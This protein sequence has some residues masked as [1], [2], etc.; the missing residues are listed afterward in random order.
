MSTTADPYDGLDNIWAVEF[1]VKRLVSEA[2][3]IPTDRILADKRTVWAYSGPV[4][5]INHDKYENGRLAYSALGVTHEHVGTNEQATMLIQQQVPDARNARIYKHEYMV[6]V[7]VQARS[8]GYAERRVNAILSKLTREY[9]V[10]EEL[11]WFSSSAIAMG[12]E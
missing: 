9:P 2:E 11:E 3:Q 4:T 6:R 12:D 8:L 7:D 1:A 5:W 10:V